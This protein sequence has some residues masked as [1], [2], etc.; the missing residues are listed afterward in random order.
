MCFWPNINSSQNIFCNISVIF[1][2]L[3]LRTGLKIY[4]SPAQGEEVSPSNPTPSLT[5][6]AGGPNH[7]SP[8]FGFVAWGGRGMQPN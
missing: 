7:P 5:W 4:H 2:V 6:G 3:A 1:F 8:P